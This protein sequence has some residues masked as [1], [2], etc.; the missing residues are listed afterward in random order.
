MKLLIESIPEIGG[1]KG[2]DGIALMVSHEQE[3]ILGI[4]QFEAKQVNLPNPL[5]KNVLADDFHL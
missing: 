4:S 1:V 3:N 2:F 5:A